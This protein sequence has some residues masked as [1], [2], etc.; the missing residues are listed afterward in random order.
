MAKA[1]S[2]EAV[3]ALLDKVNELSHMLQIRDSQ[4]AERDKVLQGALSAV[5][6]A[7]F[8]KEKAEAWEARW[9]VANMQLK[10]VTGITI[11]ELP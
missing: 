4:L 2:Q 10:G 1:N 6:L 8:Y 7:R 11:L 9:A 3:D 5:L